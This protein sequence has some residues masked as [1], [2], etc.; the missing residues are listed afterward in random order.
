[1]KARGIACGEQLLGVRTAAGPAKR[2]RHAQVEVEI[3]VVG[4]G[5]ARGA[6]VACIA[7]R[8]GDRRR[9][10]RLHVAPFILVEQAN[11][12]RMQWLHDDLFY[13]R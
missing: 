13:Q 5:Y 10:Q 8:D 11:G 7:A 2:F 9:I 3:A 4:A 12:R 1:M 6:T